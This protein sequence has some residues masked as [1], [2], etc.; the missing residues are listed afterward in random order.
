MKR[1]VAFQIDAPDAKQVLLVGD[2]TAW[3]SNAKR[4][5]RKRGKSALFSTS[6]TLPAGTYE[7]KFIVDGE[8]REDPTAET[9]P[10]C[11]GSRNSLI[12]VI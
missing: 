8:W 3:E 11:F 5:S 1:K 10:N 12:R 7:Y 9:C 2:F 4:L 6:L